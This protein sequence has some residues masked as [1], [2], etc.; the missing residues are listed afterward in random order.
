MKWIVPF[1]VML[2][3]GSVVAQQSDKQPTGGTFLSRPVI[4]RALSLQD[5][6]AIALKESPV[7]RGAEEEV[8]MAI[9]QVSMAKA[10]ARPT[11][12]TTTFL[13][14]GS[15]GSILSTPSPVMPQSLFAVPGGNFN[16]LNVTWMYPLATGGR[17]KALR[18]QAQAAQQAAAADLA[19]VRRDVVLEVKTAYRQVLLA[20]AMRRVAEQRQQATEERL[21]IDRVA[22]AEGR[23]P[24]LY[25]L[26]DEAE[27]ADAN[28]MLTN[29]QRDVDIALVLLKTVMGISPDSQITLSDSL[30]DAPPVVHGTQQPVTLETLLAIA[31]RQRPELVAA[32]QRV[33]AARQNIAVTRS[34]YQPQ[35][36]LMA[37]ADSMKAKGMERLTGASLGIIIGLPILDGGM[38]R[39]QV[40][41]ATAQT[42]KAQADYEKVALQVLREVQ[43]AWLALRAAE[44]NIKTAEA[45]I[46]AA[47]E[48]YRVVQM[49]YESGRGVN[50]EV[51]DT[52]AAL[53]RARTNR[54]QALFD[55]HVAR[56]R[57]LWAVG[58]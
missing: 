17:L 48:D 38:R 4:N 24:K 51:L 27:H 8:D 47:E 56:D 54:A 16:G 35:L 14:A 1:V 22:F 39:A 29:A 57:L 50:V 5:A 31:E 3:A 15:L 12:S 26:R 49:R 11:L 37:M 30:D 25:V 6:I 36:S 23:I 28:Q 13:T 55:Y 43:T 46:A 20:Q 41:E 21:R 53:T 33:E 2:T 18:R 10:A 19:A 9:A 7:L 32:R 40:R 42:R 44:Q 58:Q 52:L 34:T 45:A